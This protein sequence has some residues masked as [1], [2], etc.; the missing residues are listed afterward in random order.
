VKKGIKGLSPN[1]SPNKMEEKIRGWLKKHP[2]IKALS[3]KEKKDFYK[4]M[5]KM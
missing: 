5:Q 2:E 3:E 1:T 4:R